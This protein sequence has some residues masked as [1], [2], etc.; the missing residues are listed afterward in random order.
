[1]KGSV[2]YFIKY[3]SGEMELALNCLKKFNN[4]NFIPMAKK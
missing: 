3:K 1:M 4:P 2:S